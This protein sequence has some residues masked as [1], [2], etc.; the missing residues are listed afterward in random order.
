MG[1]VILVAVL[2]LAGAVLGAAVFWALK[3]LTKLPTRA[4]VATH[5]GVRLLSALLSFVGINVIVFAAFPS[6]HGGVEDIAAF[7]AVI[8]FAGI[9]AII[10][11]AGL[12]QRTRRQ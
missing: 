3:K 5:V 4:H 7:F 10:F 11:G 12:G 6:G 1:G 8:L 9:P 2:V